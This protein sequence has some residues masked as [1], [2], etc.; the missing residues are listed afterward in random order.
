MGFHYI[1]LVN[2][3]MNFNVIELVLRWLNGGGVLCYGVVG[4]V[5]WFR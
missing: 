3:L 4:L 5:G 1:I 2:G